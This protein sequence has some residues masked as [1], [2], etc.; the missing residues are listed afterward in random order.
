MRRL[1]AIAALAAAAGCTPALREVPSTAPVLPASET[2]ARVRELARRADHEPEPAERERLAV[3][4]VDAAQPCGPEPACAYWLAVAIGLQARERPSTAPDGIPKMLELL[5]TAE[6]AAP[7]LE[8][9]GP[10]RVAA[11]VLLRAPGWPFGPGDIEAGLEA[12]RRAMGID[13]V[14]PP[15][16]LALAEA[17]LRSGDRHGAEAEARAA[18]EA[19]RA[20]DDPDAADWVRDAERLLQSL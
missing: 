13:P 14:H 11:L 9:G 15:N 6:A 17:L 5:A 20:S 4:A 1:L 8:R 16:R 2:I 10:A 12:A 18:A 19:A 7:A 3:A